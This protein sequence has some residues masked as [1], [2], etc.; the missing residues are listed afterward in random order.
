MVRFSN[1]STTEKNY[2]FVD[3]VV[4]ADYV[5]GTFGTVAD[6]TFTVA[7][8]GTY[9]IMNVE[10]GDDAYSDDNTIVEGAHARVADLTLVNGAPLNI[11]SAQL[12]D[13]VAVG[14]KLVANASGTLDVSADA[15]TYIEVTEITPYGV[16]AVVVVA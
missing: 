10:S 16:N 5:N 2:P 8:S 13:E 12:P 11:T 15:S 9:V 6:G 1:I 3:A 14:D 4:A 7:E